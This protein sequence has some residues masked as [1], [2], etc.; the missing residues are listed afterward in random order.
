MNVKAAEIVKPFRFSDRHKEK[1]VERFAKNP[2]GLRFVGD[3]QKIVWLHVSNRDGNKSVGAAAI[4]MRSNA[5]AVVKAAKQLK[6]SVGL[7]D[8]GEKGLLGQLMWTV[9]KQRY[10]PAAFS[11]DQVAEAAYVLEQAARKL[12]PGGRGGRTSLQLDALIREV[13]VAYVVRQ[14]SGTF[15]GQGQRLRICAEDL[16]ECGRR[17]NQDFISVDAQRH[18]FVEKITGSGTRLHAVVTIIR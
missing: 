13:Y 4:A 1:L 9:D 2:K 16:L 3:I 12:T 14:Q 5:S 18:Q 17:T 7:L 8:D 11:V 6:K 10:A 15:A